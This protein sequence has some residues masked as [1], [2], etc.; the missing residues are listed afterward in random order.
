MGIFQT[1]HGLA[2]FSLRKLTISPH[3]CVKGPSHS[4]GEYH[5]DAHTETL[6]YLLFSQNAGMWIETSANIIFIVPESDYFKLWGHR[7]L[8]ASN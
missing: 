8:I 4:N 2:K 7:V 3:Q 5:R 6:Q 1:L